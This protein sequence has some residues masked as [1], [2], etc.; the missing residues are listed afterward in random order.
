MT[1]PTFC[2]LPLVYSRKR[3]ARVE[4]EA[5]DQ[6]LLVRRVDAAA[7]VGEVLERLAAGEPVV[8][9]ELAGHVADAAVDGD[10][11]GGRLDAEDARRAAGRPDEVEQ[12]PDRRRL[13]GAVGPEEAEDLAL[14]RLQVDVDDA[15]V[16]AVGLGELLGLDDG[17][18]GGSFQ[19]TSNHGLQDGLVDERRA[20]P[21]GCRGLARGPPRRRRCSA[22]SST[23]AARPSSDPRKS[24]P[25]WSAEP[26]MSATST[27]AAWS[28]ERGSKVPSATPW[29][30]MRAR[31][32]CQPSLAARATLH[33]HDRVV[34]RVPG[35]H[36]GQEQ[37]AALGLPAARSSE[38]GLRACPPPA[39][40]VVGDR[41]DDG[42][43]AVDHALDDR[44]EQRLL[45]VEVVVEGALRGASASRTSWMLICS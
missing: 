39:G 4:L 35:A 15:A 5:L 25:T 31:S 19:F 16:L 30:T 38:E 10:R 45:R 24:R 21:A 22:R 33:A 29:R 41:L 12:G 8:E 40:L 13:A 14:A 23:A 26:L 44:L 18:H 7:Q 3:R 11:V 42:Q 28:G 34:V 2:L 32:G 37:V 27:R 20:S 17:G 43:D 9:G 36:E 6:R 1:T